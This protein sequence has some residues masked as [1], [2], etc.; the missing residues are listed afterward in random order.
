MIL[1]QEIGIIL[2]ATAGHTV[3]AAHVDVSLFSRFLDSIISAGHNYYKR[4][5]HSLAC[6]VNELA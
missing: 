1:E 4:W 5:F 2:A 3:V 6:T